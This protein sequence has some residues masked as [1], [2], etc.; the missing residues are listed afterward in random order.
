MLQEAN[1][2]LLQ[3]WLFRFMERKII[4]WSKTR[5]EMYKRMAPVLNGRVAYDFEY[6]R[7]KYF[8]EPPANPKCHCTFCSYNRFFQI[9]IDKK[10]KIM[11]ANSNVYYKS[12]SYPTEEEKRRK[13]LF[14]IH[15]VAYAMHLYL[16]V[17]P[18]EKCLSWDNPV[19]YLF[20]LFD[21]RVDKRT[22]RK[23]YDTRADKPE[24]IQKFINFRAEAEGIVRN[25][26]SKE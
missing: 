25:K 20:A 19:A 11:I 16:N 12:E 8:T 2:C 13:G 18:I 9:V 6:C 14:E 17:W 22:I 7:P 24:W 15:D 1:F 10:E 5:K 21:R 26:E 4:M 23:I 3:A